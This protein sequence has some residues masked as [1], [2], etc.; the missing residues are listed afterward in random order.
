MLSAIMIAALVWSVGR[1][2]VP[3]D[4]GGAQAAARSSFHAGRAA[5][6]TQVW[7]LLRSPWIMTPKAAD[8]VM[9]QAALP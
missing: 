9:I 3:P 2:V 8:A 7:V 6:I 5:G 4:R 1:F